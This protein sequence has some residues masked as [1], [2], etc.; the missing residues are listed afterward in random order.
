M[1]ARER[2]ISMK[3]LN[4]VWRKIT[5]RGTNGVSMYAKLDCVISYCGEPIPLTK[6]EKII[7]ARRLLH[8]FNTDGR[9]KGGV[10]MRT[11]VSTPP[12]K[13]KPV[14]KKK[15]DK[16][17]ASWEWKKVRYEA[18]KIHG[19][20]CQCCGWRPGETEHGY[21]VVDHIKPRLKHPELALDVGNL[22]CLCNDCNMGKSN[23]YE[24]DFRVEKMLRDIAGG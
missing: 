7:A 10:R 12:V 24:D 22:Q 19:R 5:K 6:D 9:K 8:Q 21:L 23:I 20:R 14:A 2:N 4:K 11:E 3:K 1:R 17:Y 16:F 15:A 13:S 18:L